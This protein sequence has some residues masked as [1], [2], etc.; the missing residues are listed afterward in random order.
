MTLFAKD[1]GHPIAR[2]PHRSRQHWLVVA[3]L[4]VCGT[5]W[6]QQPT[7]N[8]GQATITPS[9]RDAELSK[10]IE[11][12]SS[13]TG[14]TFIVDP[15]VR[16]QVTILSSTPMSPDAFYQAFLSIL[17]VHGFVAVPSGNVIKII[18]DANAKQ[19]P[20]NDLP[21]HVSSTSDEVVTQVIAVRNVSAAQLV[22][23]LRPLIPQ[24]GHLAAYP[25]S[26]ASETLVTG[27]VARCA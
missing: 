23:I 22:P 8:Q 10:I 19:V 3:A 13:I 27:T 21:N 2:M 20:G 6:A 12:V 7:A 9:F 17:Q 11:A 18:P 16:A 5:V 25:A 26:N 14:K 24:Y 4:F 1:R 15:R